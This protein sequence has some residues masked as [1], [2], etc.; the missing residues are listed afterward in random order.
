MSTQGCTH[1]TWTNYNGGTCW[2]K[3]GPARKTD[4]FYTGNN[5]MVCGIVEQGSGSTGKYKI[6][7]VCE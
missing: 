6:G 2:M 3:Y 7:L 5:S 1:F 4:A